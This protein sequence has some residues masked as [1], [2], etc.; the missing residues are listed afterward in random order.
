MGKLG[1]DIKVDARKAMEIARGFLEQSYAAVTISDTFLEGDAWIIGTSVGLGKEDIIQ[2]KIDSK[3]GKIINAWRAGV[4][5][6][7]ILE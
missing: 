1:S 5:N 2:V 6:D 4:L 7:Q 3:T